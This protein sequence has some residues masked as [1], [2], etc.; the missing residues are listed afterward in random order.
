M[1]MHTAIRLMSMVLATSITCAFAAPADAADAACK[2]VFDAMAN[3]AGTPNHQHMTENAAFNAG[4]QNS[5]IIT[6]PTAMYVKVAGSWHRSVY[7]PRQQ[8]AELRQAYE[9]QQLTCKYLRDESVDG[10][11]AALYDTRQTQDDGGTVVDSQLW[12]SKSRGLPLKQTIDMDVGGKRGKSHSELR[13]DYT[14]VQAP[15]SVQ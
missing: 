1:S 12:I 15:D 10:E 6:T 7:N 4:P 9:Q 5:E 13:M 2:P 14:H 11:A 8:A 3:M